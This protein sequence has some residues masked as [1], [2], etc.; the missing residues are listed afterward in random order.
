MSLD[1]F[2]KTGG[3]KLLPLIKRDRKRDR[4]I[5]V[6]TLDSGLD[7]Y[8]AQR[9]RE[10][11]GNQHD[12]IITHKTSGCGKFD[13][14]SLRD[15]SSDDEEDAP[16]PAPRNYRSAI[17]SDV[18]MAEPSTSS[19]KPMRFIKEEDE[20]NSEL[21]GLLNFTTAESRSGIRVRSQNWR[22]LEENL[23][24]RPAGVK[25]LEVLPLDED[26]RYKR[27]HNG[28][29]KKKY[30]S[31]TSSFS[32]VGTSQSSDAVAGTFVEKGS[33]TYK[34]GDRNRGGNQNKEDVIGIERAK[35]VNPTVATAP[36]TTGTPS[37]NINMN[38]NGFFQGF[39]KCIPVNAPTPAPAPAP[40]PV[41]SERSACELSAAAMNLLSL[42]Q[43]KRDQEKSQKYNMNI[44]KEIANIQRRPIV[45]DDR[46][47][48]DGQDIMATSG[49]G[50]DD[51][52]GSPHT[53]KLPFNIRF[54]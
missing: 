7:A 42:L 15:A 52:E 54:A 12:N 46:G 36:A 8:I 16:R 4:D 26:E 48:D 14:I 23:V 41:P 31:R 37:V 38:W 13:R 32:S 49:D 19:R 27:V 51:Y 9:D 3:L 45:F 33:F 47:N 20:E 34:F 39:S 6:E 30:R 10:L 40:A 50:V 24:D 11:Q 22:L 2:I 43:A 18:E 35:H 44:Q 28:R 29:V 21:D 17:D 25:R 5:D 1:D 53:T